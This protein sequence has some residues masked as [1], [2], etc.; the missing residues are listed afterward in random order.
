[1]HMVGSHTTETPR[2]PRGHAF[3]VTLAPP[4][5]LAQNQAVQWSS[6]CDFIELL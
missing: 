6:S 4:V 5:I 3:L 1:M 2:G